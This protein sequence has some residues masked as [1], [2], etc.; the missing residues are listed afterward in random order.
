MDLAVGE[1]N[2]PPMVIAANPPFCQLMNYSLVRAARPAGLNHR[3]YR[4]DT[5]SSLVFSA[6][7][8]RVS[9]VEDHRA[10]R[11]DQEAV[12]PG[13]VQQVHCPPIAHFYFPY[14]YI[15]I[16]RC[17]NASAGQLTHF[18]GQRDAHF[19]DQLPDQRHC[20]SLAAVR[21]QGRKDDQ[22]LF[23]H[24]TLLL[25]KRSGTSDPSPSRR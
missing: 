8:A 1:E 12:P 21:T 6:R 5:S 11:E 10:R 25:R 19:Q 7:A 18:C 2:N 3:P 9:A 15:F 16:Y 14:I 4:A 24:P 13:P 22:T 20:P 23:T 17:G